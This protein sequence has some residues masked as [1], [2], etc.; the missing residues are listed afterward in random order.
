MVL[1]KNE[2]KKKDIIEFNKYLESIKRPSKIDFSKRV[3]NTSMD[4]LGI[5]NP[6][7]KDIAKEIHKRSFY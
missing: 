2:W 3:T 6:T 7:C 4:V 1:N 5:D